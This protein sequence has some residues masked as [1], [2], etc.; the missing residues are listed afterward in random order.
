MATTP[1]AAPARDATP[2]GSI[3]LRIE[4]QARRLTDK[5]AAPPGRTRAGFMTTK[6]GFARLTAL[7]L[8][9]SSST[10]LQPAYSLGICPDC[11]HGAAQPT[12]MDMLRDEVDQLRHPIAFTGNL[13]EPVTRVPGT[14]YN[15]VGL[16]QVT[17][18]DGWTGH[19]TA[20]VRD[21]CHVVTNAH[22]VYHSE[23]D[24]NEAT[25]TA[26]LTLHMGE[27]DTPRRSPRLVQNNSTNGRTANRN[28]RGGNPTSLGMGTAAQYEGISRVQIQNPR[29]VLVGRHY[30]ASLPSE[31]PNQKGISP[32]EKIER[33][34]QIE[35]NE[36][37]RKGNDWALLELP[38]GK[39]LNPTDYP[40]IPVCDYTGGGT[41]LGI[42][43]TLGFPG[44]MLD[45]KTKRRIPADYS[46][47]MVD[48][49]SESRGYEWSRNVWQMSNDQVGGHS[50][51]PILATIDGRQCVAAMSVASHPTRD[52]MQQYDDG[53]IPNLAVP[54]S[55]FLDLIDWYIQRLPSN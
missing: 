44:F 7:A 17:F 31:D 21:P 5:A 32:A 54:G 11:I 4:A 50:G 39:C 27:P 53:E 25:R 36:L 6:R 46:R 55:K 47:L 45:E 10:L 51:S 33:E 12:A 18:P 28:P 40:S 52:Y 41:D 14:I 23:A 29:P 20:W 3:N 1:D 38:Q 43:S 49:E 48:R 2:K 35:R 13:P 26:R 22:V 30:F 19:G 34:R 16:L 42:L 24:R 15:S 9:F 8:L 37:L